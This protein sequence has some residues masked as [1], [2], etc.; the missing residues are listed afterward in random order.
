M[1]SVN[2]HRSANDEPSQAPTCRVTFSS[3]RRSDFSSGRIRMSIEV[4]GREGD[5]NTNP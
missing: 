4:G 1:Q 2:G 5:T 3:L